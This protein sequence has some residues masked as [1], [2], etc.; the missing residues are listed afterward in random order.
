MRDRIEILR[1]IVIERIK[2]RWMTLGVDLDVLACL[3]SA[4]ERAEKL[5]AERDALI[6]ACK[7]VAEAIRETDR[8][9]FSE[10]YNPKFHVEITLSIAE[11]RLVM[12]A[13]DKA[14]GDS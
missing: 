3:L 7:P 5:Q 11:C 4:D 13:I 6:A 2:A 10:T 9:I 14:K 1:A 8:E 12:L